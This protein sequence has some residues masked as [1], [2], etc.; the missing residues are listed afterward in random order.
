[1]T[2][3]IPFRFDALQM[4]RSGTGRPSRGQWLPSS[5]HAQ[6]TFRSSSW[7]SD[8]PPPNEL[9]QL[10]RPR[11]LPYRQPGSSPAALQ[12]N[13]SVR[14]TTNRPRDAPTASFFVPDIENV[15]AKTP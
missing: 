4:L 15:V 8:A 11:S 2:R 1:M 5:M 7:R 12:L 10:P 14:W 3:V 6:P 9:L 13:F